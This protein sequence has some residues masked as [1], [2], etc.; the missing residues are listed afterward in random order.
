MT[1]FFVFNPQMKKTSEL[2]V[3]SDHQVFQSTRPHGVCQPAPPRRI[4]ATRG[5]RRSPP[6]AVIMR[7]MTVGAVIPSGKI[8]TVR[9]FSSGWT[10]AGRHPRTALAATQNAAQEAGTRLEGKILHPPLP[11]VSASGRSLADRPSPS[12]CRNWSGN[13]H[14]TVAHGDAGQVSGI[15]PAS[16]GLCRV[17]SIS[18]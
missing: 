8:V 17:A 5:M 2:S 7:V 18:P 6:S 10:G 9:G 15:V 11:P 14:R 4:R 3:D 16:G 12:S 1:Y 13:F